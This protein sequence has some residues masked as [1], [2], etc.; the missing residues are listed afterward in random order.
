MVVILCGLL[1]T[2]ERILVMCSGFYI[3]LI[4]ALYTL[5]L[6]FK[7]NTEDFILCSR[8]LFIVMQPES[9]CRPD[10]LQVPGCF[11]KHC[12]LNMAAYSL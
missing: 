4:I 12:Y 7:A 3:G 10:G 1:F 5:P 11:L 8:S 9:T 6:I 2:W